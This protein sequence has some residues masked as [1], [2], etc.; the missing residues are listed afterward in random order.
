MVTD[1][2]QTH[3]YFNAQRLATYALTGKEVMDYYEAKA[4]VKASQ[5][6]SPMDVGMLGKKGGKKGRKGKGKL[7]VVTMD[8]CGWCDKAKKD[9][10]RLKAKGM[11]PR[12]VKHSSRQGMKI[13]N[14]LTAADIAVGY[15]I[16][17]VVD[18]DTDTIVWHNI[19]YLSPP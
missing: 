17:S 10:P 16:Y 11:N 5:E 2:M 14:S 13:A 15:P 3:L 12:Y 9:R 4:G 18:G 6:P 19:G 1:V 8:G 7:V